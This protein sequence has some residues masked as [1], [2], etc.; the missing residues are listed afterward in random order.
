MKKITAIFGVFILLFCLN[1]SCQ[2]SSNNTEAN[3]TEEVKS[4]AQDSEKK[5]LLKELRG[6]HTLV[7][8]SAFIGANTMADYVLDNGKW[9]ASGSS[10]QG[11]M[12]E[13]AEIKLNKKELSLLSSMKII[14]SDDLT[15]KFTCE[16]KDYIS[17]SFKEDGMEYLLKKAPKEYSSHMS[18]KLNSSSTSLEGYT[19]LYANDKFENSSLESVDIAGVMANAAVLKIN[20]KTKKFELV[21]FYNDCCDNAIYTFN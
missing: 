3:K 1:I 4:E 14:V 20:E 6:E 16:G 8:I 12:R 15:V 7:S 21:L 10:N 5:K 17:T 13:G 2:S 9:S 19:Y 18:E 11:G